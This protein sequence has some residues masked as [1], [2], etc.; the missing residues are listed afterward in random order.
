MRV[1]CLCVRVFVCV[2]D[3]NGHYQ[4]W[5][6]QKPKEGS[7]ITF[8]L[9][10]PCRSLRLY[11]LS[12]T[13]VCVYY[14]QWGDKKCDFSFC[15]IVKF[16]MLNVPLHSVVL[17]QFPFFFFFCKSVLGEGG[18]PSTLNSKPLHLFVACVSA[19]KHTAQPGHQPNVVSFMGYNVQSLLITRHTLQLYFTVTSEERHFLKLIH[20]FVLWWIF[21]CLISSRTTVVLHSLFFL[22]TIWNMNHTSGFC[23]ES[24]NKGVLS[25][26]GISAEMF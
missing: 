12:S 3:Q 11:L 25:S 24:K 26:L 13:C 15:L 23:F 19:A 6:E 9:E 14:C 16:Y 8:W 2:R 5:W 22:C 18:H 7:L 4:T 21:I 10:N 17:F 20:F 1:D